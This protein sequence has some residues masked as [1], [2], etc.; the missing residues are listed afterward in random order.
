MREA[1]QVAEARGRARLSGTTPMPTSLVTSTVWRSRRAEHR[2]RARRRASRMRSVALVAQQQVR[3]PQR[4]AVDHHHVGVGA[5]PDS[6]RHEL[7][8]RLDRR[9]LRAALAAVA[10]D[11]L[12]P[13]RRRCACAV[14]TNTRRA[15]SVARALRARTRSCRSARRR[16][17]ES[18]APGLRGARSAI[19]SR[20]LRCE[21]PGQARRGCKP[22]QRPQPRAV[23][24]LGDGARRGD[25]SA[26][27]ASCAGDASAARGRSPRAGARAARGAAA[28]PRTGRAAS[29]RPR[30]RRRSTAPSATLH[31]VR[32]CA[33][34]CTKA[35]RAGSSEL[36]L[37]HVDLVAADTVA[38][39]VVA[40]R[41]S[42][43]APRA[44]ARWR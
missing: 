32:R 39:L 41:E 24:V 8:R 12:A 34:S 11:A 29:C 25:R 18:R 27:R 17:S 35:A 4:E 5:A 19:V 42:L 40:G 22:G 2:R 16:R 36:D 23:E 1:G 14:A 9:E 10:R 21:P 30:C 43:R 37:A 28:R 38:V 33:R 26:R 15:P 7:E 31:G 3:E 13:S 6:A 44:P 20:L